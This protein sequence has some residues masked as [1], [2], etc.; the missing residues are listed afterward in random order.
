MRCV[1]EEHTAVNM[2][3]HYLENGTVMVNFVHQKELFFLP[4]GFV[5]KGLVGFS[6]FQIFQEL[7]KGKED[8]TFYKNCV[9]QMLRLVSEEGCMT[10]KQA[11]VFLGQRFRVKMNLPEWYP[12]EQVGEFLFEY[13]FIEMWLKLY[14]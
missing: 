2:T 10:Q 9:S 14:F 12:S 6:D 1:R 13:V 7:I 4:L 8:D 11:L 5:L 3:L